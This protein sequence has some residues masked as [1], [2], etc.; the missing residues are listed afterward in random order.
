M[1]TPR[2]G[3]DNNDECFQGE[4][5]KYASKRLVTK[6]I[7]AAENTGFN[8]TVGN[9][10]SDSKEFHEVSGRYENEENVIMMSDLVNINDE[11][12]F[13]NS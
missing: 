6:L 9:L 1:S 12:Y 5:Q 4:D 10:K 3:M 7:G 2:L 11:A 8:E 13:S